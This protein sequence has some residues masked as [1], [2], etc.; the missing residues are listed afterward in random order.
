MRGDADALEPGA[1]YVVSTPIGN[2]NDVTLRALDVLRGVKVVFA[3][4]T[5]HTRVLFERHDIHTPLRALHEHNEAKSVAGVLARL[6]AGES[7]ALVSDAG[8][9]TISDPGERLVRAVW[10]AGRRVV[11]VPGPTAVAAALSAA[12]LATTPFTFLGFLPRSG[13][14]RADALRALS[15]MPHTGVL[16]ESAERVAD[17]LEELLQLGC[18]DRQVVVARELTKRFEEFT[19]GTVASLATYYA[20]SPPRG[21]VVMLFEGRQ[22][23]AVDETMLRQRVQDLRNGGATARDIVSTLTLEL[24]VARNLAY[25]LAHET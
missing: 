14:G 17:T 25:R 21:E 16:Y 19:R 12:G 15:V 20:S 8:T 11:P 18:G 23:E 7:V 10:D 5:R 6:A 4:D 22:L 3:E 9:P 13:K 2:L 24:G 1:L